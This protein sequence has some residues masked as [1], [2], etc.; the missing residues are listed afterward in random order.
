VSSTLAA[1]LNLKEGQ[2]VVLTSIQADTPAAQAGL[3]PYDVLVE[4]A[5]KPVPSDIEAARALIKGLEAGSHD[6]VIIRKGQRV[7]VKG[8]TL[9]ATTKSA[10]YD[11]MVTWM[12]RHPNQANQPNT[13]FYLNRV[14]A[15]AP[16]QDLSYSERRFNVADAVLGTRISTDSTPSTT[17]NTGNTFSVYRSALTRPEPLDQSIR[18]EIKDASFTATLDQAQVHYTV[19]GAF[20]EDKALVESITVT[21]GDKKVTYAKLADAAQQARPVIEKMIKQ[22]KEQRRG[23]K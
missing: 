17:A 13:G 22:A 1:Q 16:R 20:R 19:K 3:K 7:T 15:Q 23:K 9:S 21:S 18:L 11:H 6:A 4:L 10:E 8:I 14:A 5:G 2:G 12:R